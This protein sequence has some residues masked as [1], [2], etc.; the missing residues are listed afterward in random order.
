MWSFPDKH[1]K[2]CRKDWRCDGCGIRL[3]V[4]SE[5]FKMSGIGDGGFSEDVLCP[6][7]YRYFR[8]NIEEFWD[9]DERVYSYYRGEIGERRKESDAIP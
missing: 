9:E 5:L 4:G 7:C 1:I 8:E 3:P 2:S 6:E